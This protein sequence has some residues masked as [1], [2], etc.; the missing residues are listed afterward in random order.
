MP[1]FFKN[2]ITAIIILGA[3]ILCSVMITSVKV[4]HAGVTGG[5]V[6]V[7]QLGGGVGANAT[8]FWRGDGT[9]AAASGG[10]IGFTG[11]TPNYNTFLGT[12]YPTNA[13][14]SSNT[15]TGGLALA[16]LTTGINNTAIGTAAGQL[17]ISTSN[18]TSVGATAGT[19]HRSSGNTMIGATAGS[20]LNSGAGL[21]N[22]NTFIGMY[23]GTGTNTTNTV[24]LSDGQSNILFNGNG[25]TNVVN[26]PASFSTNGGLAGKAMCWKA[27]GK[28]LGYCS[29]IVD[30]TGGCTCN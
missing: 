11:G 9:W 29:S 1:Y 5:P 7:Q 6:T 22:Y 15:S 14:G 3:I 16:S 4:C 2:L 25:L 18:N 23:A 24:I 30:A 19:A 27:D 13:T 28:T 20:G 10:L 17:I 21:N 12:S 26:I 8:T